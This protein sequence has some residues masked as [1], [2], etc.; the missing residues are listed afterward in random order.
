MHRIENALINS[1]NFR[2]IVAN[3]GPVSVVFAVENSFFGYSSGVYYQ[4][5]CTTKIN[6]AVLLVGYGTDPV[7]GDFWILK[8]S[9]GEK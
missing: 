3:V 6:H 8:N 7:A 5:N 4:A 9:W 1:I 2:D